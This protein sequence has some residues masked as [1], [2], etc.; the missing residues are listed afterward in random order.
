ML[1]A[2]NLL[3]GRAVLVGDH[4]QQKRPLRPACVRGFDFTR[5]LIER[6]AGKADFYLIVASN[7][8]RSHLQVFHSSSDTWY[9]G[10]VEATHPAEKSPMIRGEY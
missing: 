4:K 8:Y 5:S 1:V 10:K 6:L 9:G 2:L 7:N 3:A